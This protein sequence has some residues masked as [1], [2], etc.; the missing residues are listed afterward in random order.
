[1]RAGIVVKVTPEDRRRLEAI[2]S[3][4]N[5]PQK[6]VWR[7]KIVLATADGCGTAEIMRRSGK[8]KPAV[9]TWQARFMAE[10]VE[11]LMRDKT[12][13]PGKMPL[14]SLV[15]LNCRIPSDAATSLSSANGI[16]TVDSNG[17]NPGEPKEI[18]IA[19]RALIAI[20]H[21]KPKA[22]GINRSNW[23]QASLADAFGQLYGRRPSKGTVGRLLRNARLSWKKSRKVLTSP[24][25]RYGE[26]VDLLVNTLHSLKSDEDLF[27]IDELGPLQVKR[28]GGRCYTPK[29][30]TPTYSQN[31]TARG[32][33]TLYGAL[34][35][36]T[37]QMTWFYGTT[38]DSVG[39]IDLAEILFNQNYH[40]SKLYLTWDAASWH[41]S[42]ALVQWVDDL[43]SSR[44][45]DIP[46]PRIEF[47]PLPSSAQFLN[48]IEA[49]FSAAKR[50]VI[51]NSDYASEEEMKASISK[52]FRERNEFFKI[53]PK[54]A[55]N[56]MWEIDFF[57]DRN[58]IRS[59]NYRPW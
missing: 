29:G 21:H 8:S 9:W 50:A 19:A 14:N 55:G 38:K 16:T 30:H 45:S 31:R 48:V 56:K 13:K 39:I 20:L 1:M 3:N 5:S 36:I 12:R 32:S 4:R 35:A 34:S 22:Y 47:V 46:G 27:F 51:H 10:G 24:D 17:V 53:N 59:G 37:N 49:V 23:T 43:N 40:K 7:A 54:R 58:R 57:H 11:G 44:L 33:V 52:H 25:P 41:G 26:K 15:S 2:V 6:H 42:D 28:Y 18:G